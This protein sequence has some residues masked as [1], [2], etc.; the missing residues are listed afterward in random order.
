MLIYKEQV[1][2]FFSDK[3]L[4]QYLQKQNHFT[5]LRNMFCSQDLLK[6]CI[7]FEKCDNGWFHVGEHHS[8]SLYKPR[9]CNLNPIIYSI[10]HCYV[11]TLVVF[12]ELRLEKVGQWA[13]SISLTLPII[14]MAP[15][16]LKSRD[17]KHIL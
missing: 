7:H 17:E 13:I 8:V 5:T 9:C 14:N 4:S 1:K 11:M 3:L 2:G 16:I 15:I 10:N 12:W 6:Y